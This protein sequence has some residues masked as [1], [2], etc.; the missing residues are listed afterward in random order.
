MRPAKATA[1]RI[2]NSRVQRQS[3]DSCCSRWPGERGVVGLRSGL[4]HLGLFT[5]MPSHS[6]ALPAACDVNSLV[7]KGVPVRLPPATFP[8]TGLFN[9]FPRQGDIRHIP[10]AFNVLL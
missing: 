5:R 6:I 3:W 4:I 7:R 10:A 2:M 8:K 9:N 1:S